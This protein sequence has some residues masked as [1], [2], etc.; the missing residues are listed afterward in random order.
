[1]IQ[2]KAQVLEDPLHGR[3]YSAAARWDPAHLLSGHAFP[4]SIADQS[5]LLEYALP[6]M[7]AWQVFNPLRPRM[8]ARSI[9]EV[10]EREEVHVD[11]R[12]VTPSDGR[13]MEGSKERDL[14]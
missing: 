9:Y 3:M 10:E 6:M 4:L 7:A 14:E 5:Q 1:M 11:R 13:Q 12:G 2:R 8:R